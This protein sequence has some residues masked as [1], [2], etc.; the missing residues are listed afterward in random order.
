MYS[1]GSKIKQAADR[2]LEDLIDDVDSDIK[3]DENK[4][5]ADAFLTSIRSFREE[6]HFQY[7]REAERAADRLG[8][9]AAADVYRF[10]WEFWQNADD[11][12]ATEI[13]FC[14]DKDC[15]VITN[16]GSP[17][18]ARDVYSLIFV[19]STTK[20]DH[21]GLMGQFGV[22]S[23]SLTRFSECPTYHSGNYLFTLERSFTYPAPAGEPEFGFFNGTRVIAPL[24]PETDPYELY[25][26]LS[27]RIES[28]TLL[29]MKHLERVIVRNLIN[30]EEKEACIKVRSLGAGDAVT[31]GNQEWLRFTSDV[32]PPQGM[33]RDD[34]TGV[35]EAITIT[36]VRQEEKGGSH[37]VCA[38]F[39]TQQYHQYPWR[40]SA[41]F[42]VTT[43]REN[44]IKSDF[45][46]WLLF[47]TGRTM[48]QAAMSKGVGS[49]SQP[50]DLVPL[51]G[52]E[53]ELIDLVWEGAKDEMEST[54]W[55]PTRSGHV[56]PKDAVFPET[57]EVRRLIN[58]TD[59][60]SV[61]EKRYWLLGI[62][63]R[64]A[65]PVLQSLGTLRLCCHVLS[66][67][68]AKGPRN[69]KPDWYLRTLAQIIELSKEFGDDE[70]NARLLNGKCI[71]N[72]NGQP[73]SLTASRQ[74]G[75]VVC[76][77]RSE[78][79][80]KELGGLFQN[81][82]VMILHKVYRLPDRKTADKKDEMQH[83][84]DEWLRSTSSDDTFQYETR[85]DAAAF[86]RRFVAGNN[87]S[88]S[89]EEH[90][91]RLLNFVRD[92]LEAYV[93]DRGAARRA[94]TLLELGKSLLIKSHTVGGNEKDKIIFHPV[95]DVFI[96][97]GFLD[98]S[99]WSVAAKGIPGFHWIDWRYRKS[100]VRMGNPLGVV[101]FLRA[102]GAVTSPRIEPV[103]ANY[104]HNVHKFTSVTHG[105]P[106]RFPNFPHS[107]VGFGAYSDYGLVGDYQ[108]PDLD[109]WFRHV[110]GLGHRERSMKGEALLR[111]LEEQWELIRNKTTAMATGYYANA[112]HDIGTVPSRWL[113]VVQQSNWVLTNNGAFVKPFEAYVNTE[114][115]RA[116]LEPHEDTICKWT[117]HS[118]EVARAVHLKMEIPAETIIGYLR[119]ARSNAQPLSLQRATAYYEYLSGYEAATS[120]V[121][122]AFREGLIFAP[123]PMQKWWSPEEC[124]CADHR[125]IFGNYCGYLNN[126]ANADGLWHRLEVNPGPDLNFL[127]RFWEGVSKKEF[128]Q[129][130]DLRRV[131]ERTYLFAETLL[132]VSKLRNTEVPVL[133]NGEWR[134]TPTV[135]TTEYDE[136]AT[137]LESKGLYRWDFEFADLIPKFQR[138]TGIL[139]IEQEATFKVISTDYVPDSDFEGEFYAGVQAFGTE[140]SRISSDLWSI[141]SSRIRGVLRGKVKRMESLKLEV[142]IS[143][144][145]TGEVVCEVNVPAF[146]QE[147]NVFISGLTRLSDPS[148]AAAL[149]SGL[150]LSGKDRWSL[151]NALTL[152]LSDPHPTDGVPLDSFNDEKQL[153]ELSDIWEEPDEKGESS[154]E[155]KPAKPNNNK[156]EGR[157]VP[158][159]HPV[160]EFD[161][162][163]DEGGEDPM[164]PEGGLVGRRR[165]K[166]KRPKRPSGSGGGNGP[167][168][169]SRK[170]TEQRAVDLLR[171][172]VLEPDEV[173][174]ID[175]RLTAGVGAD[176]IGDDN[177]FRELKAR[178]GSASDRVELTSHEY[179]RADQARAAYELVIVEHVWGDPVITIIRNP[180]ARLMHYPVGSV[181]VEGWRELDP[182]PR[183][184]KLRK[185]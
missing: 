70:V 93:S 108:S 175:Q 167:D 170:S 51:E 159:P 7:S 142:V 82:L 126:Y 102:L 179:A 185:E 104:W 92:H 114:Q 11:A 173:N 140:I 158:L 9:Q 129:G 125:T 13:E 127:V 120:L 16:N 95:S 22:G 90:S 146:H 105:D 2:F 4:E 165:V 26:D 59:L 124:L 163:S 183:V 72:R 89:S 115:T 169:H 168:K 155:F 50:W 45:N 157:P 144:P 123:G 3:P 57:Q 31:I 35:I 172:Y 44:L 116:L 101:A 54:P 109:K 53:H 64:K 47:E 103:E 20:A 56:Y 25:D 122:S 181:A 67:I 156:K 27:K 118:P 52:N 19:A 178:A 86:I 184:V 42:D 160:D 154:P 14:V 21:P 121:D 12:G 149:L 135:F 43:G 48:V 152:H 150:Q 62:P 69:R 17:F 80:S 151:I 1:S 6:R 164:T 8:R 110:N 73:T 139:H 100:L 174:I 112:K 106:S 180:L 171:I 111:T 33:K 145:K 68:L 133:V 107:K 15:L 75:R 38:Y 85:F 131:L 61:G 5:W 130:Q 76:N 77:A 136:L 30:G 49:P 94:Q 147:G 162:E 87:P 166:L 39:P 29:Y 10:F 18:N 96:P 81:S 83:T 128:Q 36:L 71:L 141:I 176:L 84:V 65:R 46:R 98:K 63:S 88:S 23:L 55:L 99:S 97:A 113:W 66:Q 161:I 34:G 79:L 91:D 148:L 32:L 134:K 117:A 24:K 177:V 182:K 58:N 143:L 153:P 37:P 41:P 40:F 60:V 119:A 78:V 28:E 74:S 132:D 137:S 138:W